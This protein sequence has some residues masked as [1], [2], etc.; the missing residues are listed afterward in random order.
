MWPM[1][2]PQVPKLDIYVPNS[3][4]GPF[5]VIVAIHGGAFLMG[6]KADGQLTPMLAGL[7]RGYAVVSINYRLSNEAKFPAQINDVKAAIRF[8]RANAGTYGLDPNEFAAWGGSSGGYLAAMLG[9]SGGVA[10]LEDTSQGSP[11]QSSGFRPSSIVSDHQLPGNGCPVHRQRHRPGGPSRRR[12]SRS[13]LLGNALTEVPELVKQADPRPISARTIRPSSS[14]M[15]RRTRTSPRR[16]CQLA[17]ALTTVLGAENVTLQ[18]IEGAAHA[19]P[20]FTTSE[21]VALA[22]DWLDSHR[23]RT[24]RPIQRSM[25]RGTS[26]SLTVWSGGLY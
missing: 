17:A 22:L 2:T 12:L 18:L 1:P 25:G 6:D 23:S 20:E 3:G 26:T 5:P 19:G 24:R 8:V 7:D 14:S 21:N 4:S 11:D 9:T 16:I 10:D 13:Q 15:A